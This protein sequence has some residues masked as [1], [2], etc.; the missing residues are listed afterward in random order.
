[1][2]M[3]VKRGEK[4]AKGLLA[5]YLMRLLHLLPTNSSDGQLQKEKP[6]YIMPMINILWAVMVVVSV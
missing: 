1:M 3:A 4:G 2:W 6:Q 5:G